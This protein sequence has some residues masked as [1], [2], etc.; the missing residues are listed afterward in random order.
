[1]CSDSCSPQK[2]IKKFTRVGSNRNPSKI[3][4]VQSQRTCLFSTKNP[5]QTSALDLRCLFVGWRGG[6]G[7]MTP[8]VFFFPYSNDPHFSG[9]LGNPTSLSTPSKNPSV[10]L[11]T[12]SRPG[13]TEVRS[14]KG[15]ARET[16]LLTSTKLETE[17][18]SGLPPR[19]TRNQRV[20]CI[21]P[22]RYPEAPSIHNSVFWRS[23]TI[24]KS[25]P[26]WFRSSFFV[27]LF[28]YLVI[29]SHARVD[30]SGDV[31]LPESDV[32]VWRDWKR[33]QNTLLEHLP[34]RFCEKAPLHQKR[35][36]S[37]HE[38]VNHLFKILIV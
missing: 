22:V 7:M 8:F 37:W 38:K 21:H 29:W 32:K 14:Q 26:L 19:D 20:F 4:T 10:K 16:K 24:K 35:Y 27:S 34:W 33:D 18:T 6:G 11:S 17:K 13:Y 5:N 31:H 30:F 25:H 12:F 28:W 3:L 36:P 23:E 1:M 15:K 9:L 2:R